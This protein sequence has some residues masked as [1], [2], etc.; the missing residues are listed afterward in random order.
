M[1]TFNSENLGIHGL[2]QTIFKCQPQKMPNAKIVT[3][4]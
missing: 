4:P 2:A 1:L 3:F